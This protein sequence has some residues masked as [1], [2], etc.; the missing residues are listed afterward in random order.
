MISTDSA[1][2]Q[3]SKKNKNP[4][5]RFGNDQ[6]VFSVTAKGSDYDFNQNGKMDLNEFLIMRASL[7][8]RLKT[9]RLKFRK[10]YGKK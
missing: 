3:S 7:E 6:Y 2:G 10:K 5:M 9:R 4:H 8:K 1:F